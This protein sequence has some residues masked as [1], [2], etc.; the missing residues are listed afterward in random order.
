MRWVLSI[1][2]SSWGTNQ[3]SYGILQTDCLNGELYIH[4]EHLQDIQSAV[5]KPNKL[6]PKLQFHIFELPTINQ[7]YSIKFYF[8]W[9]IERNS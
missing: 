5:K 1:N 8:I 3:A 4:G 9:Q 2:P 6:S 7:T